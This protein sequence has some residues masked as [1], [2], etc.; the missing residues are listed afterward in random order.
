[1]KAELIPIGTEMLLGNITDTDSSFLATQL[2]A[3][4]INL[5][6]VSIVGDNKGRIIDTLKRAWIRADLIITTGGLGP[7]QGDITRESIAE[8]LGEKPSI[9]LELWRE[10]QDMLGRFHREIPQA[11]VKQ[12]TVIPSATIIPNPVGTAPGWWIEKDDHIVVAMPGPPDE[13]RLMWK[14]RV[15][16]KLRQRVTGAV[17]L[18]KTIKTFGKAEAKI[19]ELL[20]SFLQLPNPTLASYA[21]ADGIYLRITASGEDETATRQ[22]IAEREADIRQLL[23]PYVWGADNDT[24]EAIVGE[25]LET[26][27]LSLATMESCTEGLLGSTMASCPDN[28]SRF[29][30]GLIA[31]CDEARVA[32]GID[33]HIMRR[34]GKE[35]SQ[36]AEA[37]A[38]VAQRTLKADI[39]IAIAGIMSVGERTA[40]VF[41][42]IASGNSKRT[43]TRTLLGDKWRMKQRAV[44]T[45]LFELR[46]ILLEEVQ[47]T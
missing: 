41:I 47:C 10:L 46:K 4:G 23:A 7:T 14:E 42:A 40:S 43:I 38:E 1:V 13:M 31:S 24:L 12:A 18:S 22:L 32:L 26:K 28:L 25:L 45:A 29:K 30:G 2:P 6:F 39:G 33:T 5:H 3:L 37:M 15:L 9:D 17:I 19:D 11:N 34:Y 8:F 35:S 21:K 36:V 27:N 20:S 16:P 44:Y